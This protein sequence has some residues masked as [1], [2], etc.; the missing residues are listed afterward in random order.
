MESVIPI[1]LIGAAIF[2]ITNKGPTG[3]K[4]NEKLLIVFNLVV[5][6][7]GFFDGFFGPGTGSFFVLAFFWLLSGGSQQMRPPTKI[8][9]TKPDESLLHAAQR[10]PQDGFDKGWA[11]ILQGGGYLYSAKLQLSC[12]LRMHG[13]SSGI[14]RI[15][16]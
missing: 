10:P 5:F 3:V 8:I 15:Y 6:G 13:L 9:A 14:L 1:L 7:I 4:K 2:F 12:M 16:R 11:L